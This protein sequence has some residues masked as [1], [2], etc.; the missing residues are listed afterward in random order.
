[1]KH[2]QRKHKTTKM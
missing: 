1:M 2:Q